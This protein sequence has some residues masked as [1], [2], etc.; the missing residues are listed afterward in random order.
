VVCESRRIFLR[1]THFFRLELLGEQNNNHLQLVR[2]R[3]RRRL[4]LKKLKEEE[5]EEA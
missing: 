2:G 5:E 1:H 3:G 4:L